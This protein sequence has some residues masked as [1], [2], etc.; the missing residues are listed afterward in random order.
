[1][2]TI[3]SELLYSCISNLFAIS[4]SLV[5]E[6]CQH[7]TDRTVI[8]WKVKECYWKVVVPDFHFLFMFPTINTSKCYRAIMFPANFSQFWRILL[9]KDYN[10]IYLICSKSSGSCVLLP[11]TAC[12]SYYFIF[13]Y[14]PIKGIWL[15]NRKPC[16][17]M[18]N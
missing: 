17:Q 1:M 12:V 11:L 14:Q 18:Q 7:S 16:G 6:L 8:L 3:L 10:I 13:F 4:Y 5:I 2:A 15:S 9:V